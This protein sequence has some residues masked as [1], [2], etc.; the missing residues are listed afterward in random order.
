MC[1]KVPLWETVVMW[2][3]GECKNDTFQG[4]RKKINMALSRERVLKRC[5]PGA[6]QAP[7]PQADAIRLANESL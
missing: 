4:K 3:G 5:P 1:V 2:R 7:A 6:Q